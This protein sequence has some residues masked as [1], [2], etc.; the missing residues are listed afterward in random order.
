MEGQPTEAWRGRS[1]RDRYPN[2][3]SPTLRQLVRVP[4]SW[5]QIKAEVKEA[6]R[7]L[8]RSVSR[9]ESR[10]KKVERVELKEHE[11][12]VQ[13]I[14]QNERNIFSLQSVLCHN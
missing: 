14:L 11:E 9:N 4:I 1:W 2:P 6:I 8:Q 10:A 5:T 13:H 3:F 7:K 12:D